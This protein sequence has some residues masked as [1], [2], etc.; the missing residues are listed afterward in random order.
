MMN[1]TVI[2]ATTY[3]ASLHHSGIDCR[4]TANSLYINGVTVKIYIATY[5]WFLSSNVSVTQS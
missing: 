5:E 2:T 3:S 4:L 1:T